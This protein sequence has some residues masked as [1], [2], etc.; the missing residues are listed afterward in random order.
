MMTSIR[1]AALSALVLALAFAGA[2]HAAGEGRII[3]TVLDEANAPVEGAKVI[4]TR[5]GTGYKL[6]KVSDKKGQVML[7][8][9]DA[10]QEYQIRLEKAGLQALRRAG[11]AQA[12]GHAPPDLH[13]AEGA[14]AAP[15]ADAPKELPGHRQGDPRLQRGGHRCSRSSDLRR[16]RRSSRRRPRSTPSWPR[17]RARSPRSTWSSAQPRGA[18]R[19]RPLPRPQAERRP[20][21][22]ARYDALKATGDGDKARGHPGGAGGGRSEGREARRSASST[23]AP[24]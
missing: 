15:A 23:R 5:P 9:L 20:G 8:I 4:L 17:P 3:A 14:P 16:R 6:E 12:G 11:E 7:L 13:P 1:R 21:L 18:G 2:L 19:R 24:S 22:R 10:T